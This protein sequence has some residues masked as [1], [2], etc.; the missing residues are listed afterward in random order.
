M[1]LCAALNAFRPLREP[2][3]IRVPALFDIRLALESWPF[4][5][6]APGGVTDAVDDGG[7][8]FSSFVVL[9]VALEVL[10]VGGF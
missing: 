7:E 10:I 8:V 6:L 9:A 3:L 5:F 4:A 2:C 1:C